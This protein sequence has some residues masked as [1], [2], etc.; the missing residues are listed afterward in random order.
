VGP[1]QHDVIERL[2]DELDRE[3]ARAHEM[4]SEH[5]HAR[6]AVAHHDRMREDGGSSRLL[7]DVA[8]QRQQLEPASEQS[9]VHPP[10]ASLIEPAQLDL[11]ERTVGAQ[12]RRAHLVASARGAQAGQQIGASIERADDSASAQ[13][14]GGYHRARSIPQ[15]CS[16][17]TRVSVA[18][19]GRVGRL[20]QAVGLTG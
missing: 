2:D 19:A 4:A 16:G 13:T 12:L 20:R 5:L 11:L 18:G 14:L 8:R 15:P 17:L 1:P 7:R 10:P 9:R 3:H 6:V